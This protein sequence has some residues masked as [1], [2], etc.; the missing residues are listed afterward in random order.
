MSRVVVFVH[1]T[2]CQ[3]SN[4]KH[5][6]IEVV[7]SK[8]LRDLTARDR[9][10]FIPILQLMGLRSPSWEVVDWGPTVRSVGEERGSR[11]LVLP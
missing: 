8:R 4:D 7:G 2:Q 5:T 11:V 3:G 1:E 6:H 9:Y 10:N